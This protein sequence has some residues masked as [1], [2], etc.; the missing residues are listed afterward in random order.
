MADP[1][2]IIEV[3]TTF[4]DRAAAEACADR[5]VRDRLAACVQ[6]EGPIRST[7]R[8]QGAVETADEWRC[9]CK[10]TPA[11]AAGCRHAISRLHTYENP[12]IIDVEVHGAAEYAAWVAA[13]VGPAP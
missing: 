5:L 7:Y 11:V 6:V 13:S 12:E 10:T 4:P 2:A 1:L 8:W 9:T 3:R